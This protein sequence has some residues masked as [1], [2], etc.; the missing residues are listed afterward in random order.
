MKIKI[1]ILMAIA[2]IIF[3]NACSNVNSDEL[4]A[5]GSGDL[6]I[7]AVVY[8]YSNSNHASVGAV[9]RTKSD[10]N[11]EFTQGESLTV[12]S[13]TVDSFSNTVTLSI[14]GV[15]NLDQNYEGIVDKTVRNGKY[16]ITYTDKDG[17]ATTA[18]IQTYDSIPFANINDGDIL[19]EDT[20]TLTWD[21]NVVVGSLRV[22]GSYSEGGTSGFSSEG[23]ENTGTHEL[24]ITEFVGSGTIELIQTMSMNYVAGFYEADIDMKNVYRV[25]VTYAN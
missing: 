17:T 21:P 24:D 23:V 9:M 25:N 6:K 12:Y 2:V 13:E 16:Y 8:E 7:D 18:E 4:A 10:V 5:T 22:R 1:K 19:S 11:I 20:V 15:L 3:S 14:G